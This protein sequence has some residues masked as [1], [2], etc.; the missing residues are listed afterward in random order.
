MQSEDAIRQR[1]EKANCRTA[2]FPKADPLPLELSEVREI[3][4]EVQRLL[5]ER[6]CEQEPGGDESHPLGYM[7]HLTSRILFKLDRCEELLDSLESKQ[8][9]NYEKIGDPES[10]LYPSVADTIWRR[11]FA[12]L[13]YLRGYST[14]C[15]VDYNQPTLR[16]I[17]YL[18][19]PFWL[20]PITRTI[21]PRKRPRWSY[22]PKTDA[23]DN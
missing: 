21:L 5:E 13:L 17:L 10:L 15:A 9:E 8:Q 6:S 1:L 4:C 22:Y 12:I 3:V 20:E 16:E 18:K 23:S 11:L 2:N 19:S 14:K 7:P